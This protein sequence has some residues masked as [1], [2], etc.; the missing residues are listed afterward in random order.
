MSTSVSSDVA[1]VVKSLEEITNANQENKASLQVEYNGQRVDGS[2][3]LSKEETQ[4]Q[5]KVQIQSVDDHSYRTLVRRKEL[6]T[7]LEICF[8]WEIDYDRSG[9]T[10]SR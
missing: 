7:F 3:R 9:C 4:S 10:E 5:P 2:N 6:K 1:F 8:V